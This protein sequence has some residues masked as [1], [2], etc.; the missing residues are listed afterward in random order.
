M[1][2]AISA[3]GSWAAAGSGAGAGFFIIKWLAEFVF[4]RFDKR[5]AAL[6]AG[7]DKLIKRLEERMASLTARLDRVEGE[8][9]E[10]RAAHAQ[11]EA[12]LTKLRGLVQ[13]LGDAKQH[14]QLIVSAERVVQRKIGKDGE[15]G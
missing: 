2:G 9:I 13:G 7:T 4:G 11:C 1:E 8:L 12:E 5:E 15:T 6:D 10:C 14:A 3:I